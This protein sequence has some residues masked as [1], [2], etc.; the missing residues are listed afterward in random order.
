MGADRKEYVCIR[1]CWHG[2]SRWRKGEIA[3]FADDELPRSNKGEIVHF[4][5]VGNTVPVPTVDPR[6]PTVMVNAKKK[7]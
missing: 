5:P 3:L 2:G 6:T 7:K 4:E 1:P